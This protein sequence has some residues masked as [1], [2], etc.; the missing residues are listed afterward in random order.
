[1]MIMAILHMSS[2][3]S[4]SLDPSPLQS[5][6]TGADKYAWNKLKLVTKIN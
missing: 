4:F 1:M 3:K 6:M 5:T 2:N